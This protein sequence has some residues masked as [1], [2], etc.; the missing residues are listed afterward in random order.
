MRHRNQKPPAQRPL[1]PTWRHYHP[2]RGTWPSSP[3]LV[4]DSLVTFTSPALGTP[5]SMTGGR[6]PEDRRLIETQRRSPPESPNL[7]PML[8]PSWIFSGLLVPDSLPPE[9]TADRIPSDDHFQFSRPFD[10]FAPRLSITPGKR[11]PPP[12]DDDS[13]SS[14]EAVRMSRV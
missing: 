9:T 6:G 13:P 12:I 4:T 5:S 11:G 2:T 10:S 3:L 14:A 7:V 8:A 1:V